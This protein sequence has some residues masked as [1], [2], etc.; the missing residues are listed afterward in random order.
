MSLQLQAWVKFAM[1]QTLS[2]LISFL[3]VFAA[4]YAFF[5]PSKLNDREPK[6]TANELL[7]PSLIENTKALCG[8][9]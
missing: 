3:S 6:S 4:L 5:L 8:C 2:S 9:S 1:P 7:I